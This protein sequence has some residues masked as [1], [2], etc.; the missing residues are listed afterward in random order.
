MPYSLSGYYS[1]SIV[2]ELTP[3][4][5]CGGNSCSHWDCQADGCEPSQNH[6]RRHDRSAHLDAGRGQV[7]RCQV[8]SFKQRLGTAALGRTQTHKYVVNWNS[9][10]VISLMVTHP[11]RWNFSSAD[12]S[13]GRQCRTEETVNRENKLLADNRHLGADA[14]EKSSMLSK[15]QG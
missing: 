3:R 8:R 13:V 1:R 7:M 4:S 10:H 15:I 5:Q 11:R 12:Y 9:M 2:T 14:V 6:E